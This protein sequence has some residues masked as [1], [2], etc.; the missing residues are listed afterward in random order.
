MIRAKID[1]K[2]I[3]KDALFAGQKGTYC[4]LTLMENKDGPDEY[5]ND[6]FVV[7]DIGKERREAGEKGPI[8]GNWRHIETRTDNARRKMHGSEARRDPDPIG[9]YQAKHAAP[10]AQ[11][12]AKPD[13]DITF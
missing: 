8:V 6:G 13:E 2:K 12:P 1:V 11:A 10:T 3:L 5:G 7:Q 4:D 9:T